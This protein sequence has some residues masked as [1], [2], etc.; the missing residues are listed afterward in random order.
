M[1]NQF[2]T[3]SEDVEHERS[4]INL[5]SKTDPDKSKQ[6]RFRD[7]ET[8]AL[9]KLASEKSKTQKNSKEYVAFQLFE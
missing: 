7:Y 3:L 2:A 1:E 4:L 6:T 5:S 8:I 9:I